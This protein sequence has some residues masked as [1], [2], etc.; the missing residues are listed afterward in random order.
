MQCAG[1][2]QPE[3]A[4]P[5]FQSPRAQQQPPPPT[6]GASLGTGERGLSPANSQQVP[7]QH[8]LLQCCMSHALDL[9]LPD[10]V[11]QTWDCSR[12]NARA[13]V[14][15][16]CAALQGFPGLPPPPAKQPGPSADAA[17]APPSATYV[18]TRGGTMPLQQQLPS[19]PPA[20]TTS[21]AWRCA[22]RTSKHDTAMVISCQ[23]VCQSA[24][25]SARNTFTSRPLMTTLY[26]SCDA[27]PPA[28]RSWRQRAARC[29]WRQRRAAAWQ[30]ATPFCTPHPAT[31]AWCALGMLEGSVWHPVVIW[32]SLSLP[33]P[34]NLLS[35]LV[36]EA[37]AN[38]RL[39]LGGC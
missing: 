23:A 21:T 27:G 30:P 16:Q 5:G 31:C 12:F 13:G 25:M 28:L 9:S 6:S 18:S 3:Q 4:R 11:P 17:A 39:W 38:Q 29:W 33:V 14:K 8:L 15:W 2:G 36:R 35:V 26:S 24:Q 19:L 7:A 37:A 34:L 20:G 32:S 22:S 10:A 1:G